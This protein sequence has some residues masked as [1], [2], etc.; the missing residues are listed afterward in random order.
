MDIWMTENKGMR[1]LRPKLKDP[2]ATM[3]SLEP[4]RSSEAVRRILPD[5]I[6][7]DRYESRAVAR[8]DRAI[9]EITKRRGEK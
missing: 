8:R 7:L 2:S 9:R 3:P 5:L 4:Q 6:K 1:P